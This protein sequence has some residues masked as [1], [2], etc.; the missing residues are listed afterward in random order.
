MKNS[1]TRYP[2]TWPAG[3]P[4]LRA[5][6]RTRAK[7]SRKEWRSYNNPA[8]PGSG[9][10]VNMQMTVSQSCERVM[11]ELARMGVQEGD[12]IIS[13]NLQTRLDG[14]PRS[15]QGEPMDPGV[16]VYWR[17]KKG[18]KVMAIDR[19]D[20]VADNL[21]AIAATLDAMR[22]IERHGGAA[23]LDR[24]FTGFTALPSPENASAPGWREV[25][26]PGRAAADVS[27]QQAEDQYRRRRSETHPDKHG[28]DATAFDL[29]QRAW[30][31]AQ[32]E[33][34]A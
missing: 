18:D 17:T 13:T 5:H 3:W 34:R 15:N 33:L 21:A 32:Q 28:G 16:A 2:L 9:Y 25:L 27:L 29:V 7:F 24:A 11:A 6:E 14:L 22:A 12:V 26:F 19:Y 31:Q 20:R 23:I 1:A 10:H 4:R 30:E 8:N